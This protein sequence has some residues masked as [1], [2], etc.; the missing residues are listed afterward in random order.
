MCISYNHPFIFSGDWFKTILQISKSEDK[1]VSYVDGII[2][3]YN[4]WVS[5]YMFQIFFIL[6]IQKGYE[7]GI[8]RI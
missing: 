2:F 6:G 8:L 3:M 5:S 1:N 4:L 7:C